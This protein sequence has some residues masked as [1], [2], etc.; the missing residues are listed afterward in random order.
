VKVKVPAWRTKPTALPSPPDEIASAL[1]FTDGKKVVTTTN[2]VKF[3]SSDII[4]K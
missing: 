3:Q 1:T 2:L 4:D